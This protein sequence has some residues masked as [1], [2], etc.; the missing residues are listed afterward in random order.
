MVEGRAFYQVS[1]VVDFA[2]SP[3]LGLDVLVAEDPHLAG[4]VLPV[5]AQEPPVE[6]DRGQEGHGLGLEAGVAA[7]RRGCEAGHGW[8]HHSLVLRAPP[9]LQAGDG[10]RCVYV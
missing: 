8:A 6:G 3:E 10:R 9:L 7:G 5:A 2:M 4:E 1:R